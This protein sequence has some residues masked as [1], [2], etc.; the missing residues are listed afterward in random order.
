MSD[1]EVFTAEEVHRREDGHRKHWNDA[2]D[3]FLLEFGWC[4]GVRFVA[5]HDLGRTEAAA[6]RRLA[7]LRKNEPG[8][9][10]RY[11]RDPREDD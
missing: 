9:V 5:E 11:W 3:R 8:L 1:L 7:W 6:R 2:E 10:A 4:L